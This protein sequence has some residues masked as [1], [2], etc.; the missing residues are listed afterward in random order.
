MQ[1]RVYM[2]GFCRGKNTVFIYYAIILIELGDE[3]VR[4]I[5]QFEISY[6]QS[7]S[8]LKVILKRET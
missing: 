3:V 2:E 5:L 6:L 7:V 8:A 4:S 1:L